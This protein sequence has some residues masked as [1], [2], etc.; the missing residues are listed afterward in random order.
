[1][2]VEFD[3]QKKNLTILL[4]C[5]IGLLVSALFRNQPELCTLCLGVVVFL[6]TGSRP[7][8]VYAIIRSAPR[9]YQAGVRFIRLN[10]ILSMYEW[11]GMTVPRVFKEIVKKHPERPAFILDDK[12]LTFQ[13]VE[14]FSNK[15]ASYFKSKGF[16]RGD[17]ISVLMETNVVYPCIW[18]GLSKIGVVAALINYNLRKEPLIHSI[19]VANSKAIILGSELGKAIE[20]IRDN[21]SIKNIPVFQY[22]DKPQDLIKGATDLTKD[23]ETHNVNEMSEEIARGSIKDNMVYIYTSGTTGLPKAAK[24]SHLRYMFMGAGSHV[25]LGIKDD[26]VIYNPLPLYHTAGGMLGVGNVFLF[27]I[28]MVLRKKFSAS[29]FFVDCAKHNCSVA[30]YIGELCRYVLSVPPKPEDTKHNIRLMFGNGLRPQIWPQFVSRFNIPMI[31]ELYGSTEGNSNL[32]NCDNQVGAIGF[33]P[34]IAEWLYP[35]TLVRCD[36]ETG[37]VIRDDKGRCIKCQPGEAG[38]FIGQI[39]PKRAHSSFNGY[40]DKA[41]SEKKVLKD[42]FKQGDTYFNSGD[43]LVRDILGYFYFKDRTGDTFRWRGENVATSEVEAIITNIVGL[44]DCT[45]YGVEFNTS[46]RSGMS[47]DEDMLCI[48][49]SSC[50]FLRLRRC[51]NNITEVILKQKDTKSVKNCIKSVK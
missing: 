51:E 25:M 5:I 15:I 22:S 39:N 34:L 48:Q 10:Y 2:L 31:G 8:Y 38:V 47:S 26:D 40:A 12:T 49:F 16:E 20:D 19:K 18:L 4:T 35:V 3:T 14:E 11:K 23:L 41:A 21:E 1:M 46:L 28:T 44:Q 42:V 33:V 13:E 32:I 50:S 37:D 36:E 43:I 7:R 30:Q 24:I 29:N 9:D 27:G 6:L 45:V 17:T